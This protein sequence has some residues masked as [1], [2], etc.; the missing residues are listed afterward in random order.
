MAARLKFVKSKWS[1]KRGRN[2]P[3]AASIAQ[4]TEAVLGINSSERWAFSYFS[5]LQWSIFYSL[6]SFLFRIWPGP[7]VLVQCLLQITRRDQRSWT[8]KYTCVR[9]SPYTVGV[10]WWYWKKIVKFWKLWFF[11]TSNIVL[12]VTKVNCLWKQGSEKTQLSASFASY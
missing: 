7:S 9:W 5:A 8:T 12:H 2:G 3:S 11:N 1:K 4:S 10:T 6:K